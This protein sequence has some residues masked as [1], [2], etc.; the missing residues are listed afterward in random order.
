MSPY[1]A[2]ARATDLT[3]LPPTYLC[4]GELEVFRDECVDY[5]AAAPARPVS[6]PSCT[7][8]RAPSTAG[9]SSPTA[10]ISRRSVAERTAALRRAL[11]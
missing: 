10:E 1:A 2:P 5:A 7:C 11:R 9:S 8:I 4:V 3:G 6:R